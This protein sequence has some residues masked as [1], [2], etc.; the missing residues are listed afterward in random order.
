MGEESLTEQREYSSIHHVNE[1]NT[2]PINISK[3]S[4]GTLFE[5]VHDHGNSTGLQLPILST[6]HSSSSLSSYPSSPL[7]TSYITPISSSPSNTCQ[8]PFSTS[9]S[10]EQNLN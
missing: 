10:L 7:P 6:S 1:R 4:V 2:D 9:P 5:M 8:F 3:S